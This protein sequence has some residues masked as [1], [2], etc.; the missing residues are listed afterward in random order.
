MSPPLKPIEEEP[1]KREGNGKIIIGASS[2]STKFYISNQKTAKIVAKGS[3]NTNINNKVADISA[4]NA[5]MRSYN[6]TQEKFFPQ[7]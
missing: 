3:R 5:G 2:T 4:D 1:Q 7:R 6:T